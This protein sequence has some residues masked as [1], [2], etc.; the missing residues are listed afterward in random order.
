VDAQCKTEVDGLWA[1]G[2][3]TGGLHGKNRLMGNSLLDILVFGRR[4]A[5]SVKDD[6]PKRGALTLNNLNQFRKNRSASLEKSP[7]FFPVASKIKLEFGKPE[8]EV[9]T[10]SS[11][12]TSGGYE[13][14]DPFAR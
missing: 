2:E 1:C 12:E 6:I 13:P 14:P 8:T 11:S 9:E 3:V 5:E 10:S 7:A 4:A